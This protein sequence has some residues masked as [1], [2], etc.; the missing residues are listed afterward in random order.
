M[1][2][3]R[4]LQTLGAAALVPRELGTQP[5]P[6]AGATL[7]YDDRAVSLDRVQTR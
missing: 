6:S 3:R 1:K 2:R 7:L 5:S 4:F